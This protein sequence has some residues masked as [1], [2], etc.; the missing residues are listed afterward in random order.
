[1]LISSSHTA[2]ADA[3][4]PRGVAAGKVVDK[5]A[6]HTVRRRHAWTPTRLDELIA[7][8]T[9]ASQPN[10]QTIAEAM[11]LRAPQI[12]GR[13]DRLR[14]TGVVSPRPRSAAIREPAAPL[15]RDELRTVLK[16]HATEA[17]P[18]EKLLTLCLGWQAGEKTVAL[19]IRL[20]VTKNALVGKAHR[21]TAFGLLS[22]RPSPI[23]GAPLTTAQ[24]EARREIRMPVAT[25]PPLP[26]MD[27]AESASDRS[28]PARAEPSVTSIR[29]PPPPTLRFGRITAC[30]WP[31]GEPGTRTFHYC[32]VP[33]DPG[34]PYCGD[35][36]RIAYA[37][38]RV[39]EPGDGGDA[40]PGP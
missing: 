18:V 22:A 27:E 12:H 35:H 21:L 13:L 25:L 5:S 19:A 37:R 6:R 3:S 9:A 23:L 38:L 24:R 34:R 16:A 14:A 32:E 17:W 20:G 7:L 10:D 39:P 36:A 8:Y 33:S 29:T 4:P 28:W 26:S 40:R 15:T 31:I 2:P 30:C 1:M 11:G